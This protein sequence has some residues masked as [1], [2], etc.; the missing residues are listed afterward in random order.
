MSFHPVPRFFVFLSLRIMSCKSTRESSPDP[1]SIHVSEDSHPRAR[2]EAFWVAGQKEV[3]AFVGS[4]WAVYEQL[5]PLAS[6]VFIVLCND[7]TTVRTMRVFGVAP[8]KDQADFPI[9]NI[10][11]PSFVN[12]CEVYL[13]GN[14]IF[15]IVDYVGFSLADLLEHPIY[16]TEREIAYIVG[17]VS[18]P[19]PFSDLMF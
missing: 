8:S 7:R 17:Q 16:P 2:R 5:L 13:F 4:P 19:L 18:P 14:E 3:P 9:L 12:I 10:R 11:H 15:S 1:S 6:N